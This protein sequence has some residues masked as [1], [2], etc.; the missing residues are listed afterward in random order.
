LIMFRRRTHHQPAAACSC[1]GVTAASKSSDLPPPPE[2]GTCSCDFN[3][4]TGTFELHDRCGNCNCNLACPDGSPVAV[5]L[6]KAG[7]LT[8]GGGGCLDGG[9]GGGHGGVSFEQVSLNVIAE[10]LKLKRALRATAVVAGAAL[11]GV[12]V[13]WLLRSHP[14]RNGHLPRP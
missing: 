6:R 8:I 4:D 1:G 14:G 3:S 10:H 9:G 5:F 11:A 12:A 2:C 7:V 13:W